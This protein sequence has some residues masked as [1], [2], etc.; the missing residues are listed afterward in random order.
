M[1][2]NQSKTSSSV[3]NKFLTDV[4]SSFMSSLNQTVSATGG[5]K[6]TI[7]LSGSTFNGCR[8]QITQGASVT[9]SAT[10]TLSSQNQMAL[11]NKL[12]SEMQNKI[13]Q[14]ATQQNGF[15]SPS[16]AN[17][18]NATSD[19]VNASNTVISTTMSSSTVQNILAKAVSNQDINSSAIWMQCDPTYRNP[20]EYDFVLD[21]NI[22]QNITAKGIADTITSQMQQNTVLNSAITDLKQT[23]T[24]KNAGL[25][26]LIS[27]LTG[28]WGIIGLVVCCVIIGAIFLLPMLLK[29]KGGASSGNAGGK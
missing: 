23:A 25:D 24:Q 26:D 20:G 7:N 16:F 13:D 28:M 12:Q 29:G 2:G 18:A 19:V 6:Q 3:T 11:V 14:A 10:G 5:T 9:A 21:Q 15:L 4:T 17:S 27:A 22:L 8:V 1:G